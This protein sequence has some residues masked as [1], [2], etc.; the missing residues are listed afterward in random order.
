MNDLSSNDKPAISVV[1]PSHDRPLR[2]L[3]L[4]NALAQ[5]TLATADFEVIVC[6]DA[7]GPE[8]EELLRE[9]QL[10]Q[11][12]RLRQIKLEP[13][14]GPAVK[15]NLGWKAARAPLI[16]FTDDDCRPPSD[17]LERALAAAQR[18]PGAIVQ[19]ATR[20]DPD[21]E[22]VLHAAPHARSQW[23][24]PPS[25][26]AQTCNIIYPREV[27][28]TTGGFDVEMT[29]AAGEDTDL[30]LRAID[31]G[32]VLVGAPDVITYHAV[33]DESLLDRL[34]SA[35]RWADLPLA[36]K[37]HPELRRD[38]PLWIFWKRR[39]VWLPL[40]L[41]GIALQRRSRLAWL[42]TIPWAIHASP[43]HSSSPRGR[44]RSLLELPGRALIDG[45]EMAAMARGSVR[46]R[47]LLL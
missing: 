17:W 8:T 44:V 41:T 26:W 24:D 21:E 32:A 18:E 20:P 2:L 29:D 30:A 6:H 5:Q 38:L 37:R 43:D 9:H 7:Q 19:G 45:A 42:M 36:V 35:W 14:P 25:V 40:A 1:V 39:H 4:L 28:E 47:S 15:R 23:I 13:G 16:V 11:D 33:L 3:W 22:Y 34:R 46:H 27:L 10:A 31:R 12:G